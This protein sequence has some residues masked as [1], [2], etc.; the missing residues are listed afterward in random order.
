[1]AVRGVSPKSIAPTSLKSTPPATAAPAPQTAPT[2]QARG[3]APA[4]GAKARPAVTQSPLSIAMPRDP[5]K[6]D[7]QT[8]K[9]AAELSKLVYGPPAEVQARLRAAGYSNAEFIS[10][11]MTGTQLVVASR[12]DAVMVAF[13]GTEA[14][15]TAT[16]T[17]LGAVLHS[18]N[19]ITTDL[20]GGSG[21]DSVERFGGSMHTGFMKAYGG[22]DG[23][24]QEAIRRAQGGDTNKPILFTGHS[25]GGALAQI[26]ATDMKEKGF[27]VASVY[28]FGQPR[29][30]DRAFSAHY[31]ELGL[32][33]KTYR[34]VNQGDPVPRL[35]KIKLDT[36]L[37]N[38]VRW[39]KG[40][41]ADRF[42]HGGNMVYFDQNKTRM[43]NP[44][45]SKLDEAT[46]GDII[47]R[48]GI[49][50]A[51][52]NAGQHSMDEYLKMVNG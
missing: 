33:S 7:P 3:W 8:A 39:V 22:V 25:L 24:L 46:T 27:N 16:Q 1:M 37:G 6:Y 50:Q 10:D 47:S 11:P 28:T 34:H 19:D 51:I 48:K 45:D 20:N 32:S 23:R 49:G 43:M 18:L 21:M 5:N 14:D 26:A 35:P 9:G 13:R 15:G 42:R 2:T 36:M 12:N 30:G 4:A 17:K 31:K 41:D 29:I 40:E 52:D 44:P 38:I